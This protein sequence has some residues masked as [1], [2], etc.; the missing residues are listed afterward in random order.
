MG[1]PEP[2]A[3]IRHFSHPHPLFYSSH[4]PQDNSSSSCVACKLKLMTLPSYTCK[5][6][7]FHIHLKCSKLPQKIRHPF[8]KN[9]LLSLISSPKYQEGKFRCDACGENGDGFSYHCG[10][11]GIDLH[12][13]CANMPTRVTHQFHPHHQLSLTF[14][15]MSPGGYGSGSRSRSAAVASF[16]CSVC[17]KPGSNSWL[18]S[19]KECGGFDAHLLCAKRKPANPTAVPS[20]VINNPYPP[21]MP[22]LSPIIRPMIN[23][24]INNLVTNTPQSPSQVSQLLDLL[25]P[26]GLGGEFGS[27]SSSGYL[28]FDPAVNQPFGLGGGFGSS[29]SSGYLGFDPSPFSAV[30]QPFGLGGGFGSSSSSGYPGFDPSVF[31]AVNQPFGL[32]G[33]F[34]SSLSSGYLGFDPS[35]LSSVDQPFRLGGG[36][37][38]SLSSGYLGFDPS[39]FP[40]V[41]PSVFAGFDPSLLSTLFSGLGFL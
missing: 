18:Y 35:V 15:L 32:G 30:N 38:S 20:P 5:P 19:C 24:M 16:R 17:Q 1:R 14:S 27:S 23:E 6:C 3:S 29:S 12:T 11:C 40:S 31:S 21:V 34:G 26:S 2:E 25:G 9:H 13:V 37:N 10:D 4:N 8:D 36:S 39:V 22:T 7:N 41:D 28:G 33:G